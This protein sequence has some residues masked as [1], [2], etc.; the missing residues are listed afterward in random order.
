MGCRNDRAAAS[1]A[2]RGGKSDG[3]REGFPTPHACVDGAETPRARVR[4]VISF[5]YEGVD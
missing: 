1:H 2:K 3:L 5:P 4:N